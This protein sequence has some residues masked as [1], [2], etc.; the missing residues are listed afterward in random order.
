MTKKELELDEY[1]KVVTYDNLVISEL[2]K[3]ITLLIKDLEGDEAKKADYVVKE[4]LKKKNAIKKDY[5][6]DTGKI[7]LKA[8]MKATEV[9]NVKEKIINN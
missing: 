8:M 5:L 4:M 2:I 7:S 6:T 3:A 1:K 9:V